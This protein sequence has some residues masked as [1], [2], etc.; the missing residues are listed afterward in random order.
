MEGAGVSLSDLMYYVL[1]MH[2]ATYLF[3]A[4]IILTKDG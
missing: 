4:A 2:K 3:L 1:L